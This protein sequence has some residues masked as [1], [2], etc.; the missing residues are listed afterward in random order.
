MKSRMV[1]VILLIASFET[2]LRKEIKDA[3]TPL[4]KD[5]DLKSNTGRL[6]ERQKT[7]EA[8]GFSYPSIRHTPYRADPDSDLVSLAHQNMIRIPCSCEAWPGARRLPNVYPCVCHRTPGYHC[9]FVS[10]P[11]PA[12]APSQS[13]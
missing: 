10:V 12:V 2:S 6:W 3:K 1:D 7:T 8:L 9:L 4:Q 5:A 11:V 13:A